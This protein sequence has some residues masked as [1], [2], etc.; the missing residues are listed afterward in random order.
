MSQSAAQAVLRDTLSCFAI[1]CVLRSPLRTPPKPRRNRRAHLAAASARAAMPSDR[2]GGSNSC[3]SALNHRD[4]T[5]HSLGRESACTMGAVIGFPKTV[6]RLCH[7]SCSNAP[8]GVSITADWRGNALASDGITRPYTTLNVNLNWLITR[9]GV[10]WPRASSMCE[11]HLFWSLTRVAPL[12]LVTHSGRTTEVYNQ[13]NIFSPKER[14]L[15][16]ALRGIKTRVRL[17]KFA[18]QSQVKSSEFKHRDEK[19]DS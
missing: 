1:V 6:A 7:S 2:Y 19:N 14:L 9:G 17:S 15:P 3:Q 5:T 18:T 11:Y 8:V 10:C 4:A 12:P 16:T 13:P